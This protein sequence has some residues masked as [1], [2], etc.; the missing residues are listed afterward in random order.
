MNRKFSIPNEFQKNKQSS[1]SKVQDSSQDFIVTTIPSKIDSTEE[2]SSRQDIQISP[3]EGYEIMDMSPEQDIP[4]VILFQR[5]E[6]SSQQD[7]YI[8]ESDSED[9]WT[10]CDKY[11][12][13]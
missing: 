5:E 1:E 11:F 4:S 10:E 2:Q 12:C 7:V 8:D 3:P 6:H 13:T 9:D